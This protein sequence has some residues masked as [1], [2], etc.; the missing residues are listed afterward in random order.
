MRRPWQWAAV[1]LAV[2]AGPVAAQDLSAGAQSIKKCLPCHTVGEG[3][4]HRLGPILN[5]LDG[6]KAGT[7]EGYKFSE[8]NKTSGLI[9]TETSFT[10]YMRNP[11]ARI[12]GTKMM[13]NGIKSNTE[14][15]ALW[16]Y[17]KQF[18]PDGRTPKALGSMAKP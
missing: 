13:F 9:W 11:K 5:G 2:A 18:G 17:L 15:A 10:E 7:A 1:L 14:I 6:R 8:A 3:A 12:P 16:A 4:E